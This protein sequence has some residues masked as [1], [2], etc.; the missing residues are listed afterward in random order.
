M[1]SPRKQGV[2]PG[3]DQGAEETAS[4]TLN[5]RAGKRVAKGGGG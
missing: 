2:K 5:K 1:T 3:N 4:T